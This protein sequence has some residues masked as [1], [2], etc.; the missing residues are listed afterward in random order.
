MAIW[1]KPQVKPSIAEIQN[2]VERNLRWFRD[3]DASKRCWASFA[4]NAIISE[5][6]QEALSA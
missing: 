2:T 6:A 5:M 1:R 3:L 4:I